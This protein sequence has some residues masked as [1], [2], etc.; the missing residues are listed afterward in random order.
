MQTAYGRHIVRC[1]IRCAPISRSTHERC[2][3]IFAQ[4][5][6]CDS[7]LIAMVH[8]QSGYAKT[9]VSKRSLSF[10][11]IFRLERAKVLNLVPSHWSRICAGVFDYHRFGCRCCHRIRTVNFFDLPEAQP[12]QP[13]CLAG[14]ILLA[15]S[16]CWLFAPSIFKPFT[17]TAQIQNCCY[18]VLALEPL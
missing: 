5:F 11:Q 12:T 14:T 15:F 6:C 10:I 7:K 1:A 16:I 2:G 17:A 8:R 3:L 4:L 9:K 18:A 13:A